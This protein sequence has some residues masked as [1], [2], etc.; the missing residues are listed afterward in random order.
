MTSEKT[1]HNKLTKKKK[2]TREENF[3]INR[4]RNKLKSTT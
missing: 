2:K 4:R 1:V 3:R